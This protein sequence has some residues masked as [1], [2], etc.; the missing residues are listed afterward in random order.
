MRNASS[1]VA[2]L[3][4][5][6]GCMKDEG[7]TAQLATET[8]TLLSFAD[9][10]ENGEPYVMEFVHPITKETMKREIVGIVD[11]KCLMVEQM[12][13][14]GRMECR[15]SEEMRK[16]VADFYRSMPNSEG[17]TYLVGGKEVDNPLQEAMDCGDCVILG[18]E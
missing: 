3:L 11:G 1:L 9:K 14:K 12:P 6:C 17:K 15:F 13:N 5:L 8:D 16:A 4:A 10:L 18:Y 7:E 2:V